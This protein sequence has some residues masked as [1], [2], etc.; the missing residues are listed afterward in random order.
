MAPHPGPPPSPRSTVS[1]L[2]SA[3]RAIESHRW[4]I[5]PWSN[6]RAGESLGEGAL[7][8]TERVLSWHLFS[9]WNWRRHSA[10]CSK[11]MKLRMGC[12]GGW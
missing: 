4:W 5:L 7:V 11:E 9:I 2:F 1:Q 8:G 12:G 3:P 6:Q 10:A